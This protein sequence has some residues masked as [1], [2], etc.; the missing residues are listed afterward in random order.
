[1]PNHYTLSV[2]L[3][4]GQTGQQLGQTLLGNVEVTDRLRL[5]ELPPVDDLV[6]A[7]L[8]EGISLLGY[9]L[10]VAPLTGG[11]RL[12]VELYWQA[13]QPIST[14]WTVFVQLLGPDGL[15]IG[16]HDGIPAEGAL[17]TTMWDMGE[18]VLDRHQ[19]DFPV[20]QIGQ[21]RLIVGMYNPITGVR[22]PITTA[23]ETTRD[24]LQL[25]DFIVTEVE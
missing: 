6:G 13:A 12:T 23:E 18:I 1:M 8:G 16:Q 9:N 4:D 2:V 17:P 25:Y 19:F 24:F 14:D 22:L 21:Y 7:N 5:F 20:S 3:Y 11:G 10:A 15:I